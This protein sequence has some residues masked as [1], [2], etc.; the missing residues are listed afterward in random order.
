[1]VSASACFRPKDTT[2]LASAAASTMAAMSARGPSGASSSR[3]MVFL[4]RY[5]LPHSI[6][7]NTPA[8]GALKPAATPAAVP[9]RNK[10]CF[11]FAEPP[12][13]TVPATMRLMPAP[14][15]TEGPSGPSEQPLPKVATA[16][17]RRHSRLTGSK[18]SGVDAGVEEGR[19][20]GTEGEVVPGE[21]KKASGE[22][23]T[24]ST[25]E[26]WLP[27]LVV[28]TASNS[29]G[30][31]KSVFASIDRAMLSMPF[32]TDEPRRQSINATIADPVSGYNAI[33]QYSTGR[34]RRLA[35]FS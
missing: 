2:R 28:V 11:S 17:S 3:R 14:I 4:D 19:G 9:A 8:M 22:Y 10:W 26:D 29:K 30:K 35:K 13:G 15:S 6:A 18:A 33:G 24:A 25:R 12:A 34:G 31:L 23:N 20:T 5:L 1:M 16:M 21:A 32:F 27:V 7:K